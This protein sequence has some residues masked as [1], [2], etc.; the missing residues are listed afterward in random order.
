MRLKIKKE[1]LHNEAVDIKFLGF[2]QSL[3]EAG[4]P[5][6]YYAIVLNDIDTKKYYELN[7]DTNILDK[8]D[9][10]KCVYVPEYTNYNKI[11]VCKIK[12]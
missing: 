7:M 1:D 9:V 5:Q 2:G 12:Y 8:I 3:Y 10:D 6:F 11:F 4:K